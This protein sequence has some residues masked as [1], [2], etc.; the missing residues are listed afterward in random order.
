MRLLTYAILSG[1]TA[2]LLAPPT[3]FAQACPDADINGDCRVDAADLSVLAR[4]WLNPANMSDFATLA[5]DWRNAAGPVIITEFM[6]SNGSTEPLRPGDLLD[7]D[8]DASD[9]IELHNM[10]SIPVDLSGWH[11]TDNALKPAQWTFAP[12]NIIPAGG[13][14]IVFASGKNRSGA[15]GRPH[16]N[17][18][19]NADGEYVAL[20]KPDGKTVAC[21]FRMYEFE[22][23]RFGFPLQRRDVSYG[24]YQ[25]QHRYFASPTPGAPNIDAFEGIVDDISFS[26]GRGFYDAP[27]HGA[28][29]CATPQAIIRYTTDGAAPTP[30][31]GEIYTQPLYI[32]STTVLRAIAH[33][34]GW[35]P[36]DICTTTWILNA[37]TAQRSLPAIS[38]VG[39]EQGAFYMPDGICAIRGGVYTG[40][41]VSWVPLYPGDYNNPMGHG[42]DFE[43]PVSVEL[44][45]PADNSGFQA[46]CG[47]RISGSTYSRS[48]FT[49]D[50]KFSFRLYF[51]KDYDQSWL[52]YPIIPS[53]PVD[54]FKRV[55]LRAGQADKVNP[56]I[57]D[58]LGRRLQKDMSGKACT[59]TF[60]N[61]FINGRHQGYYNPCER[62]DE[63]MMQTRW[64]SHLPWDVVAN[65][66]P[67]DDNYEWKPGDPVDRPYRVDARSG[68]MQS[69][70]DLLDFAL[71]HD[72][73]LMPYYE[74]ISRRMDIP[75][76]VDYLI[77]EGYCH[78]DDWP[79]NNWAAARQRSEGP[80]GL[81]RFYVWDI[82]HSF[83]TTT[84]DS[85]FKAPTGSGNIQ[86]IIILYEQLLNNTEFK[87]I[88]ADRVQKH[89]FN[90]GALTHQ[91]IIARFEELRAEM[92]G[93]LPNMN[94][95]IRDTWAH[96]RPI[97]VLQSLTEKRLFTFEGPRFLVN[98]SPRQG[99]DLAYGDIL[100]LQNPHP[101][102]TMYY[103][104]DGSDPRAPAASQT[105]PV[106]FISEDAPKNISFPM[107]GE[108]SG[109]GFALRQWYDDISGTTIA[110]LTSH[111]DYPDNPSGAEL[112]SSFEAPTNWND[113]YGTR[114]R[115][116][117]T[118]PQTQTYTF[119][120][121]SDDQGELWL[122]ADDDPDNAALIANVP[123]WTKSREWDKYDSQESAPIELTAGT[124][125]YIEALQ[126]DGSGGD[127]LA[128]AW[129]SPGLTRRIIDG[130]HLS[131]PM[132]DWTQPDFDDGTWIKG[133]GAVGYQ[134][135]PDAPVSYAPLIGIDV[136]HEMIGSSCLIRV[137]FTAKPAELARLVLRMRYD[138]AFV[139]WL[140]GVQ[141][142]R[143][144]FT[145]LPRWD[146]SADAPRDDSQAAQWQD[147]DIT[148]HRTLLREGFNVLA[149][150]GINHSDDLHDFLVSI[151]LVGDEIVPGND[152]SPAAVE[153]TDP[154]LLTETTH[155][156][157]RT[158]EQSTWSGLNEAVFS[159]P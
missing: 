141:V 91:N 36:S 50:S 35:M 40:N 102:G 81:W 84:L 52:E 137:P 118:P 72:L 90:G 147:F 6:A 14:L 46:D 48:R 59:G 132:Y 97:R 92:S 115:A 1:L 101:F 56:F 114:M 61:L 20:I 111:P 65:W 12:A 155:I 26:V 143:G 113:Y 58:E 82:E 69:F 129:Q 119:W 128:V 28:I 107:H 157:A 149:V 130:P 5:R 3:A 140:N 64:Q 103:T 95:F 138:D 85:P 49:L 9:W 63:H 148:P 105:T 19:L 74:E 41:Y 71:M 60:A 110:S 120:I 44:I 42:L 159:I 62:I 17:F 117:L 7:E 21:E 22:P 13:F 31:N 93:V 53:A 136:L 99:G 23:G 43:R 144:S 29:S 139:A 55:V 127:N 124:C 100:T 142:A 24:I 88:F 67:E 150:Q 79:H 145:G 38:L 98:G 54:R 154:I 47:I 30:T 87:I 32:D 37:S 33:R 86:P 18:K 112:M 151:E 109:D 104:R 106:T 80:L 122:S 121:A 152:F 116:W 11:L 75:W 15:A 83:K 2:V 89:L 39:D 27:F 123:G 73:T 156:R 94:T 51:R 66:R 16:T 153:Y 158:L 57:K 108:D 77:L 96:Q 126:K 131:W 146:S 76:F 45:H 135:D 70:T 68:D 134:T 4:E 34:P 78:H 133:A 10:A 25:N 8:G 125:Y